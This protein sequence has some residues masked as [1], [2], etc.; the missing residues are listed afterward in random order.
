MVDFL[1][2]VLHAKKRRKVFMAKS[3]LLAPMTPPDSVREEDTIR[4]TFRL[5]IYTGAK[6]LKAIRPYHDINIYG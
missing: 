4:R 2:M 1:V 6:Y 3:S 5:T